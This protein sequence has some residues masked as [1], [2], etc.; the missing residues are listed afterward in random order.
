MSRMSDYMINRIANAYYNKDIEALQKALDDLYAYA[1]DWD[2]LMGA[3][4]YFL[5]GKWLDDA[6]SGVLLQMKSSTWSGV[7]SADHRLGR[8][9]R[10]LFSKR[11]GWS[12][13]KIITGMAA[14][15]R[16][17]DQSDPG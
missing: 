8:P 15:R 9:Y 7:R 13:Y 16:G 5:L 4:E 11:M 1:A 12:N 2:K 17:I 3:N 6:A 14:L 10:H